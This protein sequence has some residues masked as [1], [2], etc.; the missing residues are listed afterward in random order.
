VGGWVHVY[1]Y[2]CPC[3]CVYVCPNLWS[4]LH[5]SI[6]M[7]AAVR[8]KSRGG[9]GGF[10]ANEEQAPRRFAWHYRGGTFI[11]V[12]DIYINVCGIYIPLCVFVLVRVCVCV[13]VHMCPFFGRVHTCI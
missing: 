5:I 4:Y 12:C 6:Y 9:V 7:T 3:V 10:A 8:G 11:S 2:L 1:L 13:C